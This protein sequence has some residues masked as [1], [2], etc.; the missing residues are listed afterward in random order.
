MNNF[1]ES[2]IETA[3]ENPCEFNNGYVCGVVYNA[4]YTSQIELQEAVAYLKRIN[5]EFSDIQK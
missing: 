3:I 2:A 5:M 4:L 1:I